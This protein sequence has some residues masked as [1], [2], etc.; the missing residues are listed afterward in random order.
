MTAATDAYRV[1]DD[2]SATR[3]ARRCVS[4]PIYVLIWLAFAAVLPLALAASLAVDAFRRRRWARTRC[5]LFLFWV[6]SCDMVGLA[7][8][9]ANWLLAGPWFLFSAERSLR[10]NRGLQVW[11]AG[12]LCAGGRRIFAI[13]LRVE[14][15]PPAQNGGAIVLARH[16][17]LADTVLPIALLPR[18]HWRYVLKREL[19]VHPCLDIVG[20]RLPTAFVRRGGGGD[21]AEIERVAALG[22][23]LGS[24]DAAMIFPEG[25]RFTPERRRRILDRL[26]QEGDAARLAEAEALGAVLPLRPGGVTALLEAAPDADI[27]ILSHTGL[28]DAARLGDVWRGRLV[29]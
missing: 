16:C 4:V 23:G 9:F 10:L 11:W 24:K 19:L 5:V 15:R 1:S 29:G 26:R 14:S 25:T 22:R 20:Q 2:S 12:A 18:L 28:E 7:A 8:A 6:T 13:D 21:A 17:S 3:W 27:L